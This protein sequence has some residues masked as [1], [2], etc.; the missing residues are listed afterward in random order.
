MF[1]KIIMPK[2]TKLTILSG[3]EKFPKFNSLV[4]ISLCFLLFTQCTSLPKRAGRVTDIGV[5]QG[6]IFFSN[7]KTKNKKW[8]YVTWSSDSSQKKIRIDFYT[9]FYIPL[10]TF[11]KKNGKNH[12]WIFDEKKHYI[13]DKGLNIF[14]HLIKVPLNPDIFFKLLSHPDSDTHWRCEQKKRGS[15]RCVA[16]KDQI[17]LWIQHGDQDRRIIKIKRGSQILRLNLQREQTRVTDNNFKLL[18]TDQYEKV[19]L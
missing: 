12:L 7:N 13:S 6:K 18:P 16:K 17:R 4:F 2:A 14:E 11:V 15:T 8:S 9:I 19:Q 5:W 1:V 10:A 3:R